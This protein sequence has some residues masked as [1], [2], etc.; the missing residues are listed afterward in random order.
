MTLRVNDNG[1]DREMT[2]QEEAAYQVAAARMIA[3]QEKI[4][5]EEAAALETRKEPFRRLGL[6]DEEIDK[7]LGL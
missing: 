4:K 1:I 3:E 6:T 7:V 5:Q 2:E